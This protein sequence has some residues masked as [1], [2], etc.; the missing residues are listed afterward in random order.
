MDLRATS[1]L[2]R[3]VL[4]IPPEAGPGNSKILPVRVDF[5]V[6][7]AF[8]AVYRVRVSSW[9]CPGDRLLSNERIRG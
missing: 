2:N 5:P 6:Q 3:T 4:L 8:D 9:N 7:D 1:C